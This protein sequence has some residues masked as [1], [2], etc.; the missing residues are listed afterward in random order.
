MHLNIPD[1]NSS[2]QRAERLEITMKLSLRVSGPS[3]RWENSRRNLWKEE[4]KRKTYRRDE[5]SFFS[6][7]PGRPGREGE[8]HEK[9]MDLERGV[10]DWYGHWL[11]QHLPAAGG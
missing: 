3:V 1:G 6:P 11:E 8:C 5:E 2:A 10:A 9:S 4:G 7:A